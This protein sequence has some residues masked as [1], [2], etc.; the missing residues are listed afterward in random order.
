MAR[1]SPGTLTRSPTYETGFPIF[2]DEKPVH[3]AWLSLREDSPD[4][5]EAER[6]IAEPAPRNAD[7]PEGHGLA[8]GRGAQRHAKPVLD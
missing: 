4:A 5:R 3:G 8:P 2:Y 1:V 7:G 6:A